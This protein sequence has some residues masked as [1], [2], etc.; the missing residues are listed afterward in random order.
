VS[1]AQAACRCIVSG[2]VQGVFFRASTARRARELGLV[3]HARNL[4]DGTVEVFAVGPR[5]QV[6][7]L[8]AWLEV[9]PPAARVE[10]V[11]AAPEAVPDAPP[12]TFSTG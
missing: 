4:D 2:R 7:A 3:G 1:S 8:C 11:A 6:E 10:R 5:A 12:A 9:G